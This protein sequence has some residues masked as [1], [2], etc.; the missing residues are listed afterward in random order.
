MRRAGSPMIQGNT[1]A[2]PVNGS[3]SRRARIADMRTGRGTA[4]PTIHSA[5]EPK[6]G[7]ETYGS[8]RRYESLRRRA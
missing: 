1:V 2:L 7:G 5:K 8:H 6:V 4:S 3:A